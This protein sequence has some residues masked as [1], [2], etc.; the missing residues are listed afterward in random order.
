MPNWCKNIV[1]VFG[2]EADIKA[3][4]EMVA[5]D[6]EAFS[7]NSILPVPIELHDVQS[8]VR[9]MTEQEIQEYKESHKDIHPDYPIGGPITQ[10]TS[11]R[12][13]KQYGDNN[14]YDW[15]NRNWDTK[16][17]VGDVV[18]QDDFENEWLRYEFDTAWGPPTNIFHE[19][20]KRFPN[21]RISWFFNEPGM[22][23]AGYL[24]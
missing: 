1:E 4:K 5:S 9:I 17:D 22:E 13:N 23:I 12:L 18:F 15:C 7:L 19:L 2:E 24:H 6:E 8:P 14:W 21:I 20:E 10:E 16:W 11:D 3:F